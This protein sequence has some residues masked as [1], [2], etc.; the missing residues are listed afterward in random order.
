MSIYIVSWTGGYEVPQ[1]QGFVTKEAAM[2][3]ART[4]AEDMEEGVDTIDVLEVTHTEFGVEVERIFDDEAVAAADTLSPE[5]L[6]EAA[7]NA[8]ALNEDFV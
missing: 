4:W 8:Q 7:Q 1:Y 6:V 2:R 3:T 5:A